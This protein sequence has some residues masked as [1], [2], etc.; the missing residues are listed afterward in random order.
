MMKQEYNVK[1]DRYGHI[2][3][4]VQTNDGLNLYQFKCEEEWMPISVVYNDG[5]KSSIKFIDPEGGPN[6]YNG[7]TNGE[8]TVT[9]IVKIGHW[10][11]FKLKE[12]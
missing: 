8:I 9:E 10:F 6:I 12:N 1:S 5:E 3:K 7:W 4:F 2:H 11:Y